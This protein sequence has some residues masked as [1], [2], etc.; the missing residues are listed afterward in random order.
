M[1]AGLTVIA[2]AVALLSF[3]TVE[4]GLRHVTARQVPVTL[5]AM[6]LSVIS[7]DISATAAR[8]ISARTVDDQRTALAAIEEKRVDLATVLGRMK[9]TNG[10]S[11]ALATFVALSQRLDANLAA[12]EEAIT[13][14]HRAAGGDREPARTPPIA[15]MPRSSSAFAPFPTAT[16]RWKSPRGPTSWSA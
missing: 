8:F 12:L 14:A 4:Q 6:R 16:R 5:D 15:S 13:Q 7:R 2:A 1:V 3:E 11:A 10:D 9:N